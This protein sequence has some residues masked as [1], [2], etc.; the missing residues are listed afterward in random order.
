MTVIIWDGKKLAADKRAVQ[1][2]LIR[3]VTKIRKIRG[4][5]CG[6]AGDWDY[7]QEVFAWFEN[8]ADPASLPPF[9]RDKQ[10]WVAFV[11]ITPE[12]RVLKYERS[13]YPIDFTE[14]VEREGFFAFGSGRDFAVGAMGAG[15]TIEQAVEIA[16]RYCISCGNG[17]DVLEFT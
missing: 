16:S 7:G 11:T 4:H 8:G 1:S 12:G 9:F 10:D 3:T 17:V 5:L 13:P 6:I 14:S 15:A 2:D